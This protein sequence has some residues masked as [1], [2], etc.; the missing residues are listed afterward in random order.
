MASWDITHTICLEELSD[1]TKLPEQFK[2]RGIDTLKITFRS[3][4]YYE[5]ASRYGGPDHLGWPEEGEDERTMEDVVA[6]TADNVPVPL[7]SVEQGLLFGL[8]YSYV[9]EAE[10]PWDDDHE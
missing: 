9:E 7:T 1:S 4:G 10:V 8:F 2:A 3:V 6:Y 5:P